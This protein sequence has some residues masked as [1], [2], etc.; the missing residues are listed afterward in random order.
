MP[1]RFLNKW[2]S[3][4]CIDDGAGLLDLIK[5]FI[6]ICACMYVVMYINIF[7]ISCMLCIM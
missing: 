5:L 6:C 2:R 1:I 4:T 3:C 7:I